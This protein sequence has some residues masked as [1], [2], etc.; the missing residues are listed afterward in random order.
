MVEK[1]KRE[2]AGYPQVWNSAVYLRLKRVWSIE[3][4]RPNRWRGKGTQLWRNAKDDRV[5]GLGQ[6]GIRQW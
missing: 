5:Q 6:S 2:V 3:T 4:M 1:V